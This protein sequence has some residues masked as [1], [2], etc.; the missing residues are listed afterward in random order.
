[1]DIYSRT[2]MLLGSER[3][4]KLKN[5]K[6]II[7][8]VGGVGGYVVEALAR[9]GVGC[10]SVVD[11]DVV[12]STNI[13]RQILALNSTIGK[14]KV[15]VAKD[16]ILDINSECK[17]ETFDKY[18]SPENRNEF[19][20]SNYDYV[21]D[22]IDTVTSKIDLI[23]KAKEDN[24]KIISSMGTGNKLHPE[25]FEIADIYETS[26]CPLART[27]RKLCKD[28]SISELKVVYS[29]EAPSG[30]IYSENG[31][32]VPGSISYV[33][34]SAGLLLASAVINDIVS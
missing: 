17:V 14:K 34:S 13:N 2:E 23:K 11:H 27:M 24:V 18:Y 6:V 9:A 12:S 8:G 15:D 29:K 5:S 16:R 28:N 31:K 22:C 3:L 26:V 1:M 20:L 10:I 4:E 19:K 30:E 25:M 33:P 32:S 7:F 21:V